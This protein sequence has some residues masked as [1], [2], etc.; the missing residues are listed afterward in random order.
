M[1]RDPD[2]LEEAE[3]KKTIT[4]EGFGLFDSK[5]V[6]VYTLPPQDLTRAQ[7]RDL[8]TMLEGLEPAPTEGGHLDKI[9][10]KLRA[11]LALINLIHQQQARIAE[12]EGLLNE[13]RGYIRRAAPTNYLHGKSAADTF[14]D[15][16]EQVLGLPST[17][18]GVALEADRE[19]AHGAAHP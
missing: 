17:N 4:I 3:V 2:R 8:L 16:I 15:R 11:D 12:L 1:L 10:R 13:A 19:G 18:L 5:G 6:L 9:I 14:V 7:A